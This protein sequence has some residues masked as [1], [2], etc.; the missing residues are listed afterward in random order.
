MAAD[1]SWMR[2]RYEQLRSQGLD[3]NPPT[4]QSASEPRCIIDGQEM[5]MLSANN[6]LNL[7]THP[8]VVEASIEAT[9]KY[10]AG[11]GSVRAIAGTLDLHLEAERVCAQ[12]KQVEAVLIYSSGYTANVGLIPTLVRGSEDIIISDELNHGSII[13][14]V[15]LTKASRAVYQHNDMSA[16]E[17]VLKEHSGSG[18]KLIITDG[19]FS[20]DGDVALL[21]E[22][23]EL[24]DDHDAMVFVDDC[25]GE[26][27][28]GEGRG[29]VAHFGLQGRVT[30]EIGSYSKALGVQGGIVAGSED[31]R[32]HAL[33]HSRS[34]LLSGSQPPGVAAA[35]KA[36]IEVLMSEPEHVQRLWENTGYFRGELDSLGF[37]TGVSETPIIPV[38][39][40]E[41]R[42]AQDL[43]AE[44]RKAGVMV[45]AIVFPMVARDKARVRT[46]MSAGLTREDLDDVLGKFES[47]GRELGLI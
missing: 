11:S 12:F 32:R 25:H 44:L 8:K 27:V 34:W 9:R 41:S 28:L 35:Q 4:L 29:I 15:R 24:A 10:G 38:M 47:C 16:L 1:L 31:V 20:M 13:D 17:Q 39:C 37:D 36:A 43:S 19:V 2:E 23:T 30:F 14:G 18:R 7:A 3:W 40:G 6:Y 45:G 33:N 21:D 46:Q 26:G 42:L 22:I 5:V